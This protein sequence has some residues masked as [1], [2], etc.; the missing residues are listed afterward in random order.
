MGV[1]DRS[2]KEP[3]LWQAAVPIAALTLFLLVQI[4]IFDGTP[5]LPLILASIVA[6][7]VGLSLGY[8]W[9]EIERGIV[10]GIAVALKA[11][12]ILM[13]VGMLI[14]T[15]IASGVVPLLIDYGLQLLSPSYFLLA[16]CL[17]CSVVSIATGN[18]GFSTSLSAGGDTLTACLWEATALLAERD[19][20]VLVAVGDERTD[21][22]LGGDDYAPLAVA[23]VLGLERAGA[24]QC[25]SFGGPKTGDGAAPED[26]I[27]SAPELAP[28]VHNPCR[29]GALLLRAL[30]TGGGRVALAGPGGRPAVIDLQPPGANA[31]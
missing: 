26:A 15:W 19:G 10:E 16:A 27:W 11:I 29:G 6:A 13:V 28:F 5:H 14:G 2:I 4:R 20:E 21:A 12:L 9:G 22:R 18:T 24:S 17:I 1:S 3:A 23:F 7:G 31:A 8:A 30:T 25:F